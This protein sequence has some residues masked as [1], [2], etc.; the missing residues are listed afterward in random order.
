VMLA[1]R[2]DE[3]GNVAEAQPYQTSLDARAS[4]ENEAEHYRHIFEQASIEAAR[5]WHYDL[6]ET[7]D[8]K[9]IGTVA[10]IPIVY[11][12]VIAAM[13]A[14]RDGEWRA[15]LPGPIHPAPWQSGRL[16]DKQ[17]LSSLQ[18]GHAKSLDSHFRLKDDVIGKTL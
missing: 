6:S 15:Y 14:P 18:E 7:L 12:L 1:V 8:G 2:F 17:D 13:H 5:Q 3:S 9:P 11:S 10:I 4:S 16:A